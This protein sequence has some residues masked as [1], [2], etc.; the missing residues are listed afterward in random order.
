MR[1]DYGGLST[2]QS[3]NEPATQS[4]STGS[5]ASTSQLILVELRVQTTVLKQLAF[6]IR[7]LT[8]SLQSLT[9]GSD[10]NLPK[11]D[12]EFEGYEGP[13]ML[14]SISSQSPN[15]FAR[16]FVRKRHP[17][18]VLHNKILCPLGK[19]DKQALP[20]EDNKDLHEALISWFGSEYS[21][22]SVT[23]SVNQFLREIKL[24]SQI[25]EAAKDTS[26]S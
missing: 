25:G 6:N 11:I 17:V 20:E 4:T 7:E 9:G 15:V 24:N 10:R 12:K 2:P 14:S 18:E 23:L 1:D 3:S 19:T 21:W 22:R 16:N 13:F 5:N 8:K 26:N